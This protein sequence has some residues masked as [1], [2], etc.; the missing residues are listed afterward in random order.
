M[1][2]YRSKLGPVGGGGED[3]TR[4]GGLVVDL[5]PLSA[6]ALM[7]GGGDKHD[8]AACNLDGTQPA[9]APAVGSTHSKSEHN[10]SPVLSQRKSAGK[11][12]GAAAPRHIANKKFPAFSKQVCCLVRSCVGCHYPN[13]SSNAASVNDVPPSAVQQ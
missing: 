2:L 6:F 1:A 3:G 12:S 10:T 13:I 8:G 9:S 4:T 5:D 11:M 7:G